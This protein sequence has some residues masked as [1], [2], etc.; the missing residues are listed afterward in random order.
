MVRLKLPMM[1]IEASGTFA[2]EITFSQWKNRMYARK[3]VIPF[4]PNDPKQINVRLAFTLVVAGWQT[5]LPAYQLIWDEFA[6]QFK[7]SGFNVYLSRAMKQYVAQLTTS[8]PP[9]SVGVTGDPPLDVW[10]WA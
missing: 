7:A 10:V 9:A 4:N 8:V 5:E 1:S 2:G 3:H 6:K